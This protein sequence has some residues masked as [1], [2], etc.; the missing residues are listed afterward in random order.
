MELRHLRTFELAAQTQSFTK[1]AELLGLTQAAVS[2]HVATIERELGSALFD[3]GPR[4][5]TLTELGRRVYSHVKEIQQIV[6][7]IKE[8]AGHP[9]SDICGTIKIAS[10]TVPSEWFL[11]DLL[12]RCRTL[13][14]LIQEYVSVTDSRTAIQAVESGIAEVGLVG[15]LPRAS[16][17]TSIPV[18][19]DELI[20]VV[21]PDH[22]IA[23]KG[24]I[25][26]ENLRGEPFIVR[27]PGSGSRR[28][29]EQALARI[30]I[31]IA[32]L[33]LA[34]EVN[35]NDAIR[36]AVERGVGFSFLSARAI[37]RELE[38]KRLIAMEIEGFRAAR[39]LYLIT[40]PER[41]PTRVVNAF[42]ESIEPLSV[43]YQLKALFGPT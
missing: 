37:E 11:P 27:E 15:E 17:L 20:M 40:H 16:K 22:E 3:R 7:R 21:S 32:D 2:Q 39:Q 1:A 10:S 18:A 30:G 33:R 6:D 26:S 43:S 25:T 29:V 14:P 24:R 5:V 31:G 41:M 9:L 34:M 42:I 38:D 13:Y 28:C 8:E 23:R 19:D 35:S 36:A 4:S 12:I